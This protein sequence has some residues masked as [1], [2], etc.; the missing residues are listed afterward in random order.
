MKVVESMFDIK[1]LYSRKL[2]IKK[3]TD[4]VTVMSFDDG[5]GKASMFFYHIMPGI[6]VVYNKWN[7]RKC[8]E[9]AYNRQ[10]M[11]VIEINHCRMGRYG[12]IIDDNQYIY[13][14]EGEVTANILGIKRG[15]PEFPLGFYEGIE[16]LIDVKA[17]SAYLIPIFP[18]VAEQLEVLK[19]VIKNNKYVV[20]IKQ[21]PHLD[22][23]FNELYNVNS[24]IQLSYIKIKVLE[25]LLIMQTIPV[26]ESIVESNYYGRPMLDKV[27]A[28]H[29]EAVNNLDKK[30]TLNEMSEKYNISL[31]MLKNC[32]K[33][34]YGCPYYTYIKKY[35]MHKAVHYLEET[36]LS[37]SEIAGILGYDN[38]SK[39]ISAFKSILKCT[40]GEYKNNNVFLEHLDLFGVEIE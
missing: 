29:S 7:T 33:E 6:D 18:D 14:G 36:D 34:V 15:N 37:V 20:R 30:Y 35:K 40:P 26:E 8:V 21:Q 28:V 1:E 27:K 5:A 13:L 9:A 12:C 38:S 39:F 4:N 32:F 25:I 24:V 10:S 31:T 23:I 22:Y 16:I 17:A 11:N 2:K 19:E 3:D